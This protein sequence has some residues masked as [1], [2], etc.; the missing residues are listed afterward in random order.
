ME[1]CAKRKRPFS[2]LRHHRYANCSSVKSGALF[3]IIQD[4][5]R[6]FLSPPCTYKR[7]WDGNLFLFITYKT[8]SKNKGDFSYC[9]SSSPSFYNGRFFVSS[10]YSIRQ[11]F[12]TIKPQQNLIIDLTPFI[13]EPYMLYVVECLKYSPLVDALSKVKIFPMYCLSLAYS[14]AY[15]DKVH[16]RIHFEIHNEKTSI[17]K[18]CFYALI[19]ASQEQ[20]LVNP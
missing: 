7:I 18:H 14:T 20:T 13:Y 16:E 11:P 9:S 12:L 17:S 3:E 15:Y 8:L 1:W 10:W 19:G 4:L 6:I 2:F 5:I